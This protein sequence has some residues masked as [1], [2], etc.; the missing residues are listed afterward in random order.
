[1]LFT[2]L[3]NDFLFENSTWCNHFLAY[4]INRSTID[5]C[6]HTRKTPMCISKGINTLIKNA[7]HDNE[8]LL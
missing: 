8:L 1:M 2:T 4:G 3:F 5:L 6:R 7:N